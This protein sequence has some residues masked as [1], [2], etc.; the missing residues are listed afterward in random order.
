MK[1]GLQDSSFHDSVFSLLHK[2]ICSPRRSEGY[3]FILCGHGAMN[4]SAAF[5]DSG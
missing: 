5:F 1:L 4:P 3:V 2:L